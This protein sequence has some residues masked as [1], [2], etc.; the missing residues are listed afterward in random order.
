MNPTTPTTTLESST[1]VPTHGKKEERLEINK[2]KSGVIACAN[3][4]NSLVVTATVFIQL[5]W[6]EKFLKKE[7]MKRSQYRFCECRKS[8]EE[9]KS[10]DS[11]RTECTQAFKS[12]EYDDWR[13]FHQF[14]ANL[15]TIRRD[16]TKFD[17]NIA[18]ACYSF[19]KFTK[20]F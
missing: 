13:R 17:K 5:R 20:F 19:P 11:C 7:M 4:N 3:A 14:C 10:S 1:F 15:S 8:M 9:S 18:K 12:F 16:W 6:C 2:E